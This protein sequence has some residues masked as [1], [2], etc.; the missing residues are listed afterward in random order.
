MNTRST[1]FDLRQTPLTQN[2]GFSAAK[3][4][5]FAEAGLDNLFEVLNFFPRRYVDRR[6][7]V[8]VWDAPLGEEVLV[9]AR[10]RS[11][12]ARY[13]R[14]RREL[15]EVLVSDDTG[16]LVLT[17]FNQSWRKRQLTPGTECALFGKVELFRR[18]R[19]MVNPVVDLIGD[20][21]GRIVPIYP[22]SEKFRIKSSDIVK[23]VERCLD[24]AGEIMDPVPEMFLS[25]EH[26]IDRNAAYQL[27]HAPQD[28]LDKE[29]ARRRL[30]F[31]E[32]LRIQLHLVASKKFQER[33]ERGFSHFVGDLGAQ[34][35][36]S[37]SRTDAGTRRGA[38]PLSPADRFQPHFALTSGKDLANRFL[39]SLPFA[40]TGAQM[41]VIGEVA[42]DMSSKVPMHRLLQGDV[43]AGKTLVAVCAGLFAIQ[44]GHQTALMAPTEVLAEQHFL[45]ISRLLE[46]L[47]VTAGEEWGLFGDVRRPLRVEILTNKVAGNRRRQLLADLAAGGIDFLI[48]THALLSEGVE[49]ASLGLAVIDEQHRFGVEQRAVLRER[50]AGRQ[51][52]E[53]DVLVM[54]ATPIPRSAAMT[55]F[56]DLDYSVLDELPPGRTPIITRWAK[57]PEQVEKVFQRI[58]REIGLGRQ[59][60]VVCALV[61]DSE[62]IEAASAKATF[63]ELSAGR[64]QGLRLGLL[65]GQLPTA[66][67]AEV[68]DRFRRGELD[69]LVATTVIEVGV[70]VPN[71]TVMVILDAARFGIA[72]IH[73][74][75]GRVGR[76]ASQSYCYLLET[77]ELDTQAAQRLSACVESTDGF[78]LAERDLDIRGEGT[79][80]GARQKGS[81]DLRIASLSRDRDIL[82]KA[83]EVAS[84]IVGQSPTL[85]SF[86]ELKKE[87]VQFLAVTDAEFLLRD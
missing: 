85:S 4:K 60:Y 69:V 3:V 49:F 52:F 39:D 53:P 9:V 86:P 51:S 81:T 21:T 76:G 78:Y 5:S 15:V 2:L 87:L 16:P 66:E 29:R 64:L 62:K 72:Q 74:L 22:Q 54:T 37:S 70:D 43:G 56:G 14:N 33:Q 32:L 65:H 55:V 59:A 17:F 46:A 38:K 84:A 34:A 13:L 40:P 79:L 50:S 24:L 27:I 73:Q 18:Q 6:N 63:D 61:E 77:G 71:A 68:M 47:E 45:G 28:P 12:T 35:H 41:R 26:L 11:V 75:R 30:A 48:G 36:V 31:D 20:R 23:L 42:L 7:L 57:E 83:R 10:V 19:Q 25:A 82:A 1:L 80:L 67:K 8:G 58:L 44:S